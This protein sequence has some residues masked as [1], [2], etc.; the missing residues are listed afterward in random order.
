MN[1]YRLMALDS[2]PASHIPCDGHF[3]VHSYPLLSTFHF[4]GDTFRHTV[5]SERCATIID[6]SIRRRT[7][8]ISPNRSTVMTHTDQGGPALLCVGGITVRRELID[9]GIIDEETGNAIPCCGFLLDLMLALPYW[10][11]MPNWVDTKYTCSRPTS[12]S[13]TR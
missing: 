6:Y 11:G 9:Q 13:R 5:S 4:E 3:Y 10:I 7:I 8:P 12:W 1:S 2:T